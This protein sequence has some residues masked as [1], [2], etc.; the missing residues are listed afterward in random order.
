MDQKF[1]CS[2][3]LLILALVSG[4]AGSSS[5]PTLSTIPLNLS[6]DYNYHYPSWSP[7]GQYIAF[8]RTDNALPEP[9]SIWVYNLENQ[10]VS[11]VNGLATDTFSWSPDGR[12]IAYG[13][14]SDIWKYD[15]N[16]QTR[17]NLTQNNSRE[18]AF[19]VVSPDGNYIAFRSNLGFGII[20]M[21]GN[22]IRNLTTDSNIIF[23][24][25]FS[26]SNDSQHLLAII[27]PRSL[28]LI[29]LEGN[30]TTLYEDVGELTGVA[31]WSPSSNQIALN[32]SPTSFRTFDI[33]LIDDS[34]NLQNLTA[35][36]EVSEFNPVWSPNGQYITYLVDE[37]LGI[38]D[39]I[40][41]NYRQI[42][43]SV[44]CAVG[45]WHSWSP[46]NERITFECTD[47]QNSDIW[48]INRDG[49]NA[50]NLTGN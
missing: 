38:I 48:I 8:L 20:D 1:V 21:T 19:P 2:C 30:L 28:V 43:D 36:P 5:P 13:Q 11:N 45:L 4:C 24:T 12:Y 47:E 31:K 40:N 29:D 15:L 33:Y 18:N 44:E 46:D 14:E 6:E 49:S 50:I 17:V 9:K 16:E 3:L 37:E 22:N 7:D 26:W 10:T 34:L 39:L 41:R 32:G 27:I 35:S 42:T 23:N 25:P